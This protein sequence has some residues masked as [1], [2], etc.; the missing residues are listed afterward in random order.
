MKMYTSYNITEFQNLFEECTSLNEN[1]RQNTDEALFMYLMK[2]R[3]GQTDA[4]IGEIFGVSRFT[5]ERRLPLVRRSLM[6]EIVPRY[7]N[8][9]RERANLISHRSIMSRNLFYP[10]VPNRADLVLDG[11]YIYVEK[12]LNH[13]VQRNT[14]SSHKKRNYVKFM[15]G[16]TTDGTIVF[17]SGPYKAIENDAQITKKILL[18]NLPMLDPFEPEDIVIVDRG[19]RDCQIELMNKGY[20][21]K[22]PAC[23]P[24]NIQFSTK[25]ANESRF[26]TKVRYIIEQMN[27]VIKNTFKIFGLT[28]QTYWLPDI[29]DDF[30]I[31]A[32]LIN[33]KREMENRIVDEEK[34]AEVENIATLMKASLDQENTLGKILRK[35]EFRKIITKKEYNIIE[36]LTVFPS[37]TYEDMY[38]ICFGPYQINQGPISQTR[39]E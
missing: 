26:V 22:M 2:L 23:Q 11:T 36:D 21:V 31:A 7:L 32:A 20:I 8:Y 33:K 38:S 6:N 34:I 18:Q 24:N 28:W 12:S 4:E 17:A 37:L 5:V 30:Q 27:S 35:K 29:K 13:E 9:K 3:T 10:E 19:F 1:C 39:Q 25:E 15:L 14:Y 16:V